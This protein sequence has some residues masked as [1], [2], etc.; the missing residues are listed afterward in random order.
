MQYFTQFHKRHTLPDPLLLTL[1]IKQI[2]WFSWKNQGHKYDG[3]WPPLLVML[4]LQSEWAVQYSL[5]MPTNC[6]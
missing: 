4:H 5:F 1:C 2:Y 3:H 6:V